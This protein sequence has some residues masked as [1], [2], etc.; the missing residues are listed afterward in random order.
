[1]T[2][3]NIIIILIALMQTV[4]LFLR[5]KKYKALKLKVN[6]YYRNRIRIITE[7]NTNRHLKD[8][9]KKKYADL[10]KEYLELKSKQNVQQK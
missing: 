2:S 10:N 5:N 9:Y 4:R 1:M 6:D 8:T 3:F 7:L